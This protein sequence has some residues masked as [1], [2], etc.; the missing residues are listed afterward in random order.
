MKK[1]FIYCSVILLMA[2]AW[3]C[4]NNIDPTPEFTKSDVTFTAT[5]SKTS[6]APVAADSLSPAFTITWN[7][8]KYAVGLKNSKFSVRF[9]LS[10]ENFTHYM[11]KEFVGVLTG[12]ILGK[13]INGIA[14]ALGGK[15]GE[16]INLDVIVV[17]SQENNN[18]PK[19][20][21][22]FALK[23]TP[24][25]D[26]GL[27]P[28]TTEVIATQAT[29]D[30]IGV[31]FNWTKAFNGY[32]GVRTYEL[33]YVKGGSDFSAA[34]I[35]PVSSKN[36]AYTKL[37]LN[38]IALGLGTQPGVAGPVD[39]RLK[40]TNELGAI[41]YS[42]V[43]TINVTPY[44]SFV[45]IGI[46]GDAT[47]GGWNVDTDM[48]RP[49]PGDKPSDWTAIV[50]LIG[51]KHAKFR[52]NDDWADNWGATD[53]PSG[54]GTSGGPDIPISTS[55]Y[56]RVNLNVAT[57]AYSFTLVSTDSYSSISLIGDQ[58]GWGP[59]IADLVKDDNNDQIWSGVVHLT[60][61][62]LK[63]RANH[64]W[65]HNWGTVTGTA[66]TD[67]SGY[68]GQD[69]G[70]MKITEEGDYFVMINIATGE[71]FFG[72]AD[73]KNAYGD[74]GI[75]GSATP[76]GWNDDTDLIRNPSNPYKWSKT[77]TLTGG[78]AKFRADNG[79]DV[80]WGTT[81]FPAGAG[82]AGGPN[83]PVAEGTYFI[84]FN[85]ATGDYSFVKAL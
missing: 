68:S 2:F 10:G 37:Q 15:V 77:L 58:S 11:S 12:D 51:G 62:E 22:V 67:L 5:P 33:Q 84:S 17:A 3:S 28:S 74:I 25:T 34:T 24:G 4:D 31:V 1:I 59:D 40:A 45:S 82:T 39:F 32:D 38:K 83:I 52:A 27:I 80:N 79:W 78:E 72:K 18:E 66:K 71:Y 35:V 69:G 61:G 55:G 36:I 81:T 16:E 65:P 30:D 26:L 50:Y 41:V 9:G 63:F 53:F 42:N 13:D 23:V 19:K 47:A 46:I 43:A 48:H 64:D 70:N 76:G 7:D 29:S 49:E 57:G 21:S 54:T 56:Y 75:I 44:V 20:S 14:I 73:R 8:P 6:V 60:V 85:T